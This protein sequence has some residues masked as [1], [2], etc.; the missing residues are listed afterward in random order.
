M[1]IT[2]ARGMGKTVLLNALEEV[3]VRAG[4]AT[5]SVTARPGMLEQLTQTILPALLNKH[6]PSAT[7][8]SVTSASVNVLGIGGS[9]GRG[10]EKLEVQPD[11]RLEL[12]QLAKATEKKGG[13]VFITIDEIQKGMDA[14]LR[15]I[16]Q[17]IQHAFRQGLEVAFAGAGLPSGVSGVLKDKVL[18]FL[19][20]AERHSL[21]FLPDPAVSSALRQPIVDGGRH[22][23]DD[24]L[25]AAVTAIRGYAYLVQQV[26]FQLWEA[27]PGEGMI[28]M[29]QAGLAIP[30]A[31]EAANEAVYEPILADLSERDR[32]F[33][34][35]MAASDEDP[36]PIAFI[37]QKLTNASQYRK[38]LIAAEAIEPTSR[39]K[40]RFA[41]PGLR[42]YLRSLDH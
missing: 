26:G 8:S 11:F 14:E 21:N 5:V 37:E 13:G 16:F 30:R 34:Q 17:A 27:A 32:Q 40:I 39:G 12:E 41:I 1:L 29:T 35:V 36:V 18:T 25:E 42:E 4:W 23:A 38:R 28:G 20:R 7:R 24:A 10:V 31:L 19:R 6:D 2:G 15:E 3:A 22:I 33:L 9:V